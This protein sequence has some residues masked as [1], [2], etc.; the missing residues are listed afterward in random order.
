MNSAAEG[1]CRVLFEQD[2]CFL[3][4]ECE[5]CSSLDCESWSQSKSFAFTHILY[6]L[7]IHMQLYDIYN[8][9]SDLYYIRHIDLLSNNIHTMTYHDISWHIH[10]KDNRSYD[11]VAWVFEDG[12]FWGKETTR[13]AA[14]AEMSSTVRQRLIRARSSV[15]FTPG[16]LECW[17]SLLDNGRNIWNIW[18]IWA[19]RCGHSLHKPWFIYVYLGLLL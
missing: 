9:N 10:I 7:Y 2:K 15:S 11:L 19:I 6:I 14:G 5:I 8:I 4:G 16:P 12:E 1:Q 3:H 17:N 13:R 18:E